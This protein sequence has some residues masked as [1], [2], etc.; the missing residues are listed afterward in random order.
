[1][2]GE[3]AC[4]QEPFELGGEPGQGGLADIVGQVG[5][6]P[7]AGLDVVLQDLLDPMGYLDHGGLSFVEGSAVGDVERVRPACGDGGPDRAEIAV[8]QV[9][10]SSVQSSR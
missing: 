2:R 3:G 10:P 6:A 5:D 1:L 8:E 9:G 7:G 4:P